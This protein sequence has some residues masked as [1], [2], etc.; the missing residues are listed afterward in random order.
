MRTLFLRKALSTKRST[1]NS[2]RVAG[3]LL[4]CRVVRTWNKRRVCL[5]Q[6]K[7]I[8]FILKLFYKRSTLCQTKLGRSTME[9]VVFKIIQNSLMNLMMSL[10]VSREVLTEQKKFSREWRILFKR[11][12]IY[13]KS[14]KV[15]KVYL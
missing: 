1:T 5:K 12:L 11:L 7:I 15:T 9:Q 10:S 8:S 13:R 4:S 2:E 3:A 6:G 14:H